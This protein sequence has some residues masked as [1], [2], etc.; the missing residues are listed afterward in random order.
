MKLEVVIEQIQHE[1]LAV[2]QVLLFAQTIKL[3]DKVVRAPSAYVIAHY[4][5]RKATKAQ[6]ASMLMDFW[7]NRGAGRLNMMLLDM[8]EKTLYAPNVFFL[9][10]FPLLFGSPPCLC[11]PQGNERR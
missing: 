9:A 8:A 7:M 1:V 4:L 11:Y 10:P 6:V 3:M 2:K 5:L